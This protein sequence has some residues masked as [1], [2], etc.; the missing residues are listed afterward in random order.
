MRNVTKKKKKV[1]NK[2]NKH[3]EKDNGQGKAVG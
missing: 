1:K 3:T 2:T